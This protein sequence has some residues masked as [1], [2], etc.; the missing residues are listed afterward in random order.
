MLQ[1]PTSHFIDA[2]T[3]AMGH[4]TGQYD[5][6]LA[7]LAG[8]Y[9]DS[10]AFDSACATEGDRIVYRVRD[11][12]PGGT[13]G[14]L[15]FGTTHMEPGRI[16]EEYFMTRGH[17]HATANR[18]E[19]YYGESGDGV[20]ILESPAGE[21]RIMPISARMMIYVPPCWIHRSVNVG[22]VPLVMTFCYPADSGQD[23]GII[24]RSNGMATRI[25]ADGAGW[26][27]VPNPDYRPR[28]KD[29]IA[30]LLATLD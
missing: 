6:R 30:A 21:T 18:P 10:A 28:T 23:Y 5:K 20:M 22:T 17:I 16:G 26:K 24:A 29:E 14:D 25:V 11:V 4:A 12:K 7:D 8:L 2:A 9:A 15:A 27:A 1:E 13:T 19:T 3:G